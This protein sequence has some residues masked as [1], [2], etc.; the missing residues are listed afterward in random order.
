MFRGILASGLLVL[1]VFLPHA[2]VHAFFQVPVVRR[3]QS[4][5]VMSGSQQDDDKQGAQPGLTWSKG[6][7]TLGRSLAASSVLFSTVLGGAG[8]QGTTAWAAPAPTGRSATIN[9]QATT[10]KKQVRSC[11]FYC[12]I[13]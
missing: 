13:L 3:V 2:S 4:G 8:M 5:V 7:G 10:Q 9:K 11:C 6:L 1:A 12:T